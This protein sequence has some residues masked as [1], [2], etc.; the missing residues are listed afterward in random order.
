VHYEWVKLKVS[1]IIGTFIIYT[2]F[3]ILSLFV[4]IFMGG[5]LGASIGFAITTIIS[6]IYAF[7]VNNKVKVAM[8]R[9]GD[10]ERK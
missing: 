2:V 6:F 1:Y 9:I 5:V 4:G 3:N 7:F 10:R 8:A